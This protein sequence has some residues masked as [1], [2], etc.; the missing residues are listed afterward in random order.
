MPSSSPILERLEATD[1]LAAT[2]A[3]PEASV[4]AIISDIPY[5]IGAADWDVL[6]DNQNSAY[7]GS[8]PAQT[9]AGSVF[10]SR[11]KPINGWSN[12]DR[13]IAAEYQA[14]CAT[15]AEDWFRVLKPGGSALV[16]AGRRLAHRA[17]AALEDVGFN[18]KDQLAWVKPNAPFRAQRLSV[19]FERRGDDEAAETWTDWR[20]GN[21]RP[22][23]EPI[24][25]CV[26]PYPMG[27]TIT[28]NVLAHGVGAF[29]PSALGD[30]SLDS[31]NVLRGGL[32]REESGLHSTQKPLELMCG[33]VGLVTSEGDTVL[34]PFA[35]SGTTLAAAKCL[36]RGYIGFEIDPSFAAVAA[37]RLASVS[38]G[39]AKC[40][41]LPIRLQSTLPIRL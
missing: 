37:Q 22:T 9:R 10:R 14:W 2:R 4:A 40:P 7:R 29:N 3:L 11:G 8:S 13:N 27:S 16:F 32:T 23:Y 19:V 39:D 24:I 18:L 1:G 12:A 28:D 26:K 35:G 38:T 6:H 30:L 41:T 20:L 15:W 5:G 34:D 33:L 17:I 25:W 21:L 31:S 36:G